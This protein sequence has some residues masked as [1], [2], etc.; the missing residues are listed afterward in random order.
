VR[1]TAESVTDGLDLR[2]KTALVTGATSGLGRECARVLALRGARVV[3]ACRDEQKGAQT[4]AQIAPS[5]H[6]RVEARACEL[7][8]MRSVRALA[9]GIHRVELVFLNG[10]VFGVP[11]ELTEDGFER[12]YAANY[13]GHFLLVHRLLARNA[14]APGARIVSTLSEGV[15]NPLARV[16]LEMLAQPTQ[17]R[18]SKTMASPA[19]KILL[20]RMAV[21]LARRAAR[22][23]ARVSMSGAC[24]PATLTDN[25][26]QG[27]PLVRALGRAIGP[28]FFKPVEEGAAV[29]LWAAT[30]PELEGRSGETLSSKLAPMR[31]PRRCTD[32]ALASA[33]WDATERALELPAWP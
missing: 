16:R 15:L 1:H 19:T 29:L 17:A 31:L 10:G 20:A 24:P 7:T 25:V 27:G 13:L 23:G 22:A 5:P 26:N 9:E 6:A 2:D 32:P 33:S 18:F 28:V 11:Y 14:L 30:S 12:T 21:E 4:I 8:S 3:I